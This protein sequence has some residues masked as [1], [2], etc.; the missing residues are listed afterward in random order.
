MWL[1]LFLGIGGFLVTAASVFYAYKS[2][3][4]SKLKCLKVTTSEPIAL[5]SLADNFAEDIEIRMG[6]EVIEQAF[7]TRFRFT[8]TGVRAIRNPA[9]FDAYERPINIPL[10]SDVK[11][12]KASIS[13]ASPDSLDISVL[14]DP[15]HRV[16]VSPVLLNEGNSFVLNLVTDSIIDVKPDWHIEDV[17]REDE[18]DQVEKPRRISR[19]DKAVILY[20]VFVTTAVTAIIILA[21][22]TR[23]LLFI[24]DLITP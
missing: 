15:Q 13:D 22:L 21:F 24:A 12:L 6:G 3:L 20:S 1:Q 17:E 2:Y 10:N 14:R 5:I 4:R 23:L 9:R 11:L 8:N 18:E 7:L 19:S 16:V